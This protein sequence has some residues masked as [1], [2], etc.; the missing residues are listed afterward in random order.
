VNDSAVRLAGYQSGR[1]VDA[2][3]ARKTTLGELKTHY[4]ELRRLLPE[5]DKELAA[6]QA[7]LDAVK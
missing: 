3:E 7:A 1:V 6:E 4:A 5:A 2:G